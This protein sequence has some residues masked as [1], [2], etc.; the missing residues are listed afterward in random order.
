MTQF[1]RTWKGIE[2]D[3][4]SDS[5][6]YKAN[7]S[8]NESELDEDIA[9]V[10]DDSNVSRNRENI[11]QKPQYPWNAGGIHSFT[12]G[13]VGWGYRGYPMST[14][15]LYQVPLFSHSSLNWDSCD[16]AAIMKPGHGIMDPFKDYRSTL[17][18]FCIPFYSN[19]LKYDLF[20][21]AVRFVHES[22][23]SMNQPDK[24]CNRVEK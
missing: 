24:N 13:Y 8:N 3:P 4:I 2:Q 15:T 12:G 10:D 7:S 23:N 5:N 21:H 14:M 17:E 19:Q 22:M 9:A 16:M 18:H 20:L 6:S 11:L 1:F